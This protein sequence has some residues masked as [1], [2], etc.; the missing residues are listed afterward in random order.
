MVGIQGRVVA[1]D[2]SAFLQRIALS[3]GQMVAPVSFS[4]FYLSERGGEGGG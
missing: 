3:W 2:F 1:I 4:G